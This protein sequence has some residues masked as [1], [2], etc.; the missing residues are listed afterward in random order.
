[1]ARI[2]SRQSRGRGGRAR[3]YYDT[4]RRAFYTV[5]TRSDPYSRRMDVRL[6]LR[7]RH[8]QRDFRVTKTGAVR[9]RGIDIDYN[10]GKTVTPRPKLRDRNYERAIDAQMTHATFDTPHDLETD[11]DRI[12]IRRPDYSIV[13]AQYMRLSDGTYECTVTLRNRQGKTF[14][15]VSKVWRQ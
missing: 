13:G 8:T 15:V 4:E 12:L 7:S 10:V 5:P 9:F 14:Q 2:L 6:I 1:M 3:Y 11:M